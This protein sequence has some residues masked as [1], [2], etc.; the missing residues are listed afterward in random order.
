[1][2]HAGRHHIRARLLGVEVG[3]AVPGIARHARHHLAA[4]AALNGQA[5]IGRVVVHLVEDVDHGARGSAQ[6]VGERGCH[7]VAVI[8][9]P[10]A[11]GHVVLVLHEVQAHGAG[12]AHAAVQVG[13]GAAVAIAAHAHRA[14][15]E[16]VAPGFL[17]DQVD[18]AAHGGHARLHRARAL[19]DLGLLQVEGVGAAGHAAVAHAVDGDGLLGREAADG[20]EISPAQIALARGEGD[21][22]HVLQ[23]LLQALGVLLADQLGRHHADALRR[24]AQR[25]GELGRLHGGGLIGRR[26]TR[27]ADLDRA[28]GRC[29]SGRSLGHGQGGE[30]A[31]RQRKAGGQG[32]R[33]TVGVLRRHGDESLE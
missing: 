2:L 21:A 7:A 29:R 13:R 25:L 8:V 5:A 20:E 16:R 24:V 23:H 18:A 19:V 17:A 22:G 28:Q 10:V 3:G 9:R 15:V 12:L 11:A 32:R 31:Q 1:M 26:L 30:G 4:R 27:G 6:A 33:E 14:V